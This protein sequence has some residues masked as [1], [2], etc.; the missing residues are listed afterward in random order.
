[1]DQKVRSSNLFGR[2][3]RQLDQIAYGKT[4]EKM[5]VTFLLNIRIFLS[6]L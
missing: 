5:L 6:S 4:K 2:A 1:M 3:Y